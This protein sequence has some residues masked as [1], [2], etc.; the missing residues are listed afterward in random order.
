MENQETKKQ[1]KPINKATNKLPDAYL[2]FG[3]VPPQALELEEAVLGAM[4][5][6]RSA[7]S[8]VIDILKPDV[9]YKEAHKKIYNAILKLFDKGSQIDILT[10][11][12]ELKSSG[13]L[14]MVGGP[15]YI[16]MLTSRISSTANIEF[17]ARIVIQ[18]YIQRELIRISSEIIK[19]A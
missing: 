15:Y 18:K 12:N 3:K 7:V 8:E 5:L 11:T 17:H 4:M 1:K 9:F 19:D 13:E 10:V 6:E 14:D 2:E 16:T